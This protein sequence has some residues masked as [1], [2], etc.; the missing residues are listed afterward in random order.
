MNRQFT[1]I[2]KIAKHENQATI[3]LSKLL[4]KQ[5]RPGN[6][7]ELKIEITSQ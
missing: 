1:I 7:V 6:I 2:K 4:E 3:V 5:L